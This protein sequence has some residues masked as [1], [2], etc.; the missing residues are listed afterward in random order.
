MSNKTYDVLNLIAKLIA[1]L[2][3][4]I[5]ALLVIWNVPYTEQITATLAAINTFVGAIVVTAKASY[6][7][8]LR[9]ENGDDDYE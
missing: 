7:K 6:D 2:S 5:S 8:R 1:P 9:N 4:L 3:T